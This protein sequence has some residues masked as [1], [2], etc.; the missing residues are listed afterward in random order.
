[1]TIGFYKDKGL[2]NSIVGITPHGARAEPSGKAI[3]FLGGGG[4]NWSGRCRIFGNCRRPVAV[5]AVL[6]PVVVWDA[7]ES[8][9]TRPSVRPSARPPVRRSVRPFVS[10]RIVPHRFVSVRRSPFGNKKPSSCIAI[11]NFSKF[12]LA[13]FSVSLKTVIFNKMLITCPKT[14]V[15]LRN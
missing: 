10:V 9:G 13:H 12:E 4:L 5:A 15:T 11:L 6:C 1:M 7:S 14:W 3:F 2:D 8:V